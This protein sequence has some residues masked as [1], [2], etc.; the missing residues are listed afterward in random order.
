MNDERKCL[1]NDEAE[2]LAKN[3]NKTNPKIND[4]I[5]S[6]SSNSSSRFSFIK[7]LFGMCVIGD[8]IRVQRA[9]FL[10]VSTKIE[11]ALKKTSHSDFKLAIIEKSTS[12]TQL[13]TNTNEPKQYY[14]SQN[15]ELNVQTQ[16]SLNG[17]SKTDLVGQAESNSLLFDHENKRARSWSTNLKQADA[18]YIQKVFEQRM[19]KVAKH[20]PFIEEFIDEKI[21]TESKSN[22]KT[23]VNSSLTLNNSEVSNSKE[24]IEINEDDDIDVN[25]I[26]SKYFENMDK[27]KKEKQEKCESII[28]KENEI[29]KHSDRDKEKEKEKTTT[30]SFLGSQGEFTRRENNKY[31]TLGD[32]FDQK[33]FIDIVKSSTK[34]KKPRVQTYHEKLLESQINTGRSRGKMV[35]FVE[36]DAYNSDDDSESDQGGNTFESSLFCRYGLASRIFDYEPT[37]RMQLPTWNEEKRSTIKNN[38]NLNSDR[39][40]A[41]LYNKGKKDENW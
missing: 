1:A 16:A 28:K 40:N 32:Y 33:T 38:P 15:T 12:N 27:I 6:S 14:E 8:Y 7:R 20:N 24:K 11:A 31:L 5:K 26:L 19:Q 41:E 39:E 34:K 22:N 2:K 3:K 30:N 36:Y 29:E 18:D 13:L 9:E 35:K 10:P 25:E 37:A 4:N 23:N 17:C 21:G